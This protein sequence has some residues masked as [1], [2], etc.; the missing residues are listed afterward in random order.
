MKIK[1]SLLIPVIFPYLDFGDD[2]NNNRDPSPNTVPNTPLM[3][4]GSMSTMI[5]IAETPTM[6]AQGYS[7]LANGLPSSGEPDGTTVSTVRWIWRTLREKFKNKRTVRKK[8]EK[9]EK[10]R[11]KTTE[12]A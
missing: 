8:L 6:T 9:F 7:Q 10:N 5:N 12:L 2:N 3:P 1:F 11:F 4:R